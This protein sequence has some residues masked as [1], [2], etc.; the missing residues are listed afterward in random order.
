MRILSIVHADDT[1]PGVFAGAVAERGHELVEWVI[2]SDSPPPGPPDEHGAVLIL[3]GAMHPD[4]DD[5]HPWLAEEEAVIRRLLERGVPTLGVCLGGQLIARALDAPVERAPEPEIGWLEVELTP[6]AADDPLFG[7]L[8]ERF[9]ACQWH[10][11]RFGLPAGAVPLAR[12]PVCLQAYRVGDVAWGLQFHAEVSRESLAYWNSMYETDE[13]AVR[14][15][16]DPVRANEEL[17][18]HIG[19]W[20]ELGREICARFLAVAERNGGPR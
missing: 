8:P 2:S 4:Q 20:N 13:E 16:F 10:S 17:E 15:G 19:R 7:G 5:H 1:G 14:I 3:G 12:S 11:Y 9:H 18:R 6:E